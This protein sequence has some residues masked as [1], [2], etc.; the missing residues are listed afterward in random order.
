ME[1][2]VSY[3]TEENGE[4]LVISRRDSRTV[5]FGTTF[6]KRLLSEAPD[7]QLWV[8]VTLTKPSSK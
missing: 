4:R 6:K 1:M 8:E 5:E 3:S 2:N 7:K